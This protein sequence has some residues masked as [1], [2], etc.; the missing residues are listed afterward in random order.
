M[1]ELID[2]KIKKTRTK[3]PDLNTKQGK[4]LVAQMQGMNKTEAALSAGYPDGTHTGRIEN[5]KQYQVNKKTYY[6]DD[7]LSQISM[8]EI[9]QAHAE[10]IR[11]DTDKGARNQAIKMAVDKIE[12]QDMPDEDNDRVTVILKS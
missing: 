7:L 2:P 1:N 10:N 9:A 5:S 4:Y 6:K 11:Q 3:K 12:P 8:K